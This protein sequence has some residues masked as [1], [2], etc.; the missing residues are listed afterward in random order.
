MAKLLI[1]GSTGYVGSRLINRLADSGHELICTARDTSFIQHKLPENAT[2]VQVD[3]SQKSVTVS[4]DVAFFLIHALGEK[5]RFETIEYRIA[6]NV[7]ESLK[8]SGVKRIIYLGGLMDDGSAKLSPHMA[9]RK[10]VGDILRS[11]GIPVIEL[12]ASVILGSGSL[13]F[14]LIRA[15]VERLPVMVTPKWVHVKAQPVFIDDVIDYLEQSISV[16]LDSSITV[17]IGGR[18]VVSYRDLMQCYAKV[19]GLHRFMISIPLLTPHLS[20]LWL[21]LITPVYARVGRKLIDS[22]TEKS[23]VNT[24]LHQ[25]LFSVKPRSCEEAI[26]ACL[27]QEDN[28]LLKMPWSNALSSST[29]THENRHYGNRILD[30]YRIPISDPEACFRVIQQIGG[31]NGWYFL[32]GLWV[33]R[34]YLDLLFGGI[35]M[36]RGRRHPVELHV[37]DTLDWWRVVQFVPGKNLRLRAEMKLPGRAWLDFEMVMIDGGNYLQQ[38]VIYDPLGLLG[39]VYWYLLLPVHGVLFKGM[40]R[41][42]K[43]L[44]VKNG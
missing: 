17:E 4:C 6:E 12:R 7:V 35:G 40:L 29:S 34:G 11:S 1:T 24:T 30:I 9:S 5:K 8:G 28:Y 36:R 3:F 26:R 44:T 37:G 14:E 21:G 20:S 39:L 10:K 32:T 41:A 31:K 22:I 33:I 38:T 42:I 23:V 2:A 18:D 25:H 27:V 43:K 19:R 16:P 13:S 15:L